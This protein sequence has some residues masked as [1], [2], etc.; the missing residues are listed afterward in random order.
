MREGKK[1]QLGA[2]SGRLVSSVHFCENV[3]R[4]TLARPSVVRSCTV[5]NIVLPS[6]S[7]CFRKS[8]M[9]IRTLTSSMTDG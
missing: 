5:L 4:R 3:N 2:R 9:P 6:V 8:T 7:N 1:K